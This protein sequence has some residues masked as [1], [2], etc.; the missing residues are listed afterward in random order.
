LIWR[1]RPVL[2][3]PLSLEINVQIR[4]SKYG[5]PNDA[6]ILNQIIYVGK[7]HWRHS[8]HRVALVE[9]ARSHNNIL[10]WCSYTS[11][12]SSRL[13]ISAKFTIFCASSTR[14]CQSITSH[15]ALSALQ[16]S[17]RYTVSR[18]CRPLRWSR[19]DLVDTFHDASEAFRVMDKRVAQVRREKTKI[20]D[21]LVCKI[22]RC[23]FSS[24]QVVDLA[25]AKEEHGKLEVAVTSPRDLPFQL[26][27]WLPYLGPP[28]PALRQPGLACG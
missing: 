16:T 6:A 4:K 3:L 28:V 18:F 5:V 27:E 23:A 15:V 19:D 8:G 26:L 1:S 24:R 20:A 21:Y 13:C 7:I 11:F 22:R 10:R 12:A 2:D 25:R 14:W 9:A 17:E